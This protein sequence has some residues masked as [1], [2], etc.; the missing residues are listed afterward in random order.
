MLLDSMKFELTDLNTVPNKPKDPNHLEEAKFN[1]SIV[2]HQRH[3]V[4]IEGV[5]MPMSISLIGNNE[6]YFG[7][8]AVIYNRL[9]RKE[10]GV[11]FRVSCK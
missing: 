4:D 9:K 7:I 3:I 1:F 6:Q 10:D 8:K 2:C 11:F 5:K